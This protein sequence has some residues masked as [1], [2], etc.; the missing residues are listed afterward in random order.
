MTIKRILIAT[1]ILLIVSATAYAVFFRD[2]KINN[3]ILVDVRKNDFE[4]NI[5]TTG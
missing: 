2:T 1:G 3:D 4:V 5:L